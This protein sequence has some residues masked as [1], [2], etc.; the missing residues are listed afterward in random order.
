M[1]GLGR[2]AAVRRKI[3]AFG[4]SCRPRVG[5]MRAR[6]CVRRNS[7]GGAGVEAAARGSQRREAAAAGCQPTLDPG[8]A[9]A[10]PA[11]TA[12]PSETLP[13]RRSSHAR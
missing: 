5:R 3:P 13:A 7:G 8:W 4:P 9:P 10:R 11:G 2:E 12:E 1:G 6:S